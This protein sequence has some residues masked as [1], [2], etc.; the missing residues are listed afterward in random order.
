MTFAIINA[1][2][3]AAT[4][5]GLFASA[6]GWRHSLINWDYS[7]EWFFA[8]AKVLL[9]IGIAMRLFLWDIVWGPLYHFADYEP[10]PLTETLG[11]TNINIVPN[12]VIL[13]GVYCSLKARQ[14]ILLQDRGVNWHWLV[15]WAYP[16]AKTFIKVVTR[17][18]GT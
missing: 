7:P 13:L 12:A 17:G 1:I 2:L 6:M 16:R 10:L 14:M 9:A 5:F 15:A 4:V 3:S 18:K 8:A 11:Q